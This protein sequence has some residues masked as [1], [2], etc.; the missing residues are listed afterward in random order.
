[1]DGSERGGATAH[2]RP[3]PAFEPTTGVDVG[4]GRV[5]ESA[6]RGFVTY[7]GAAGGRRRP[8]VFATWQDGMPRK[9]FDPETLELLASM[10]QQEREQS[11]AA[12]AKQEAER[13]EHRTAFFRE[14]RERE[15]ELS[16]KAASL[17]IRA[18]ASLIDTRAICPAATT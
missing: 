8:T 1:M 4:S 11:E 14:L 7:G 5:A 13:K 15:M 17:T 16:L 18:R 9:R 3:T 6:G 12:F 10:T 2:N